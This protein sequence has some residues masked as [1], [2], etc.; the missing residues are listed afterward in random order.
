VRDHVRALGNTEAF[1][2]SRRERKKIEMRFTHMK[3]VLKL[4][5]LR[6]RGFTSLA[7]GPL[8]L[9]ALKS[10]LEIDQR[11]ARDW[12]PRIAAWTAA[13]QSRVEGDLHQWTRFKSQS[14][15][16]VRRNFQLHD[17]PIPK[18]RG[19][20]NR[21][22]YL[23]KIRETIAPLRHESA[24]R[25]IVFHA[26][27]RI[28]RVLLR[29]KP[30]DILPGEHYHFLWLHWRSPKPLFVRAGSNSGHSHYAR[31]SWSLSSPQ[32]VSLPPP[33]HR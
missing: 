22:R 33:I 26:F 24:E 6:L 21:F 7:E 11:R 10:R 9:T 18:I 19:R 1:Q 4:D 23:V 14:G 12:S 17:D 20:L 31:A 8:D 5:R 16:V 30:K 29:Q 3:R 25:R 13:P 27:F 15:I 32:R 2:Q 28:S